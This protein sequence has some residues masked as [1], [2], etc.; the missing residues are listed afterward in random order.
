MEKCK[1]KKM[2]FAAGKTKCQEERTRAEGPPGSLPID[3]TFVPS[4]DSKG[5]YQRKQCHTSTGECWCVDKFGNEEAGTRIRGNKLW[6]DPP[7]ILISTI[8]YYYV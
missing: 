7:G 1:R 5:G 3:G 4:C 8:P 6:C 2:F